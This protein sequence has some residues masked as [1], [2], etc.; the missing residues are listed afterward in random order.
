MKHVAGIP[1]DCKKWFQCFGCVP[2]P[3]SSL[4]TFFLTWTLEFFLIQILCS[5]MIFRLEMFHCFEGISKKSIFSLCSRSWVITSGWWI[6]L[7][8]WVWLQ[9]RTSTV[10]LR[11]FHTLVPQE[12][13]STLEWCWWTWPGWGTWQE[14]ASLDQ[15]GQRD[16]LL[17]LH[18]SLSSG[19][20]IRSTSS[21]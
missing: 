18:Q 12:W 13:V 4:I 17:Q 6:R 16:H 11:I 7:K 2:P 15:S 8:W 10:L 5:L 9:W 14:E 1:M 3:D 21:R 20:F 19:G